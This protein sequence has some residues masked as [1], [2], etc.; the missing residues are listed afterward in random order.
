S[1]KTRSTGCPRRSAGAPTRDA[2]RRGASVSASP[3]P[4]PS[5]PSPRASRS[6]RPGAANVPPVVTAMVPPSRARVAATIPTWRDEGRAHCALALA[7]ASGGWRLGRHEHGRH[8][9]A[10]DLLGGEAESAE[11]ERLALGGNRPEEAEHEPAH[12]VPP[13][14][15][16]L[17]GE[18]LAQLVDRQARVHAVAPAAERLHLA[19][20]D[21]VLVRDLA[22]QLLEQV[23]ERDQARGRAVLVDDDRHVELLA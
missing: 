17:R 14:P 19:L 18:Q 20:L 1:P 3:S 7:G 5:H 21:V 15:R 22:D 11:H 9:A 13:I 4:T 10:L 12:G 2:I 16:Q 6:S 23:L 8:A